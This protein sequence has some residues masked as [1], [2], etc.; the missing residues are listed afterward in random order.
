[1]PCYDKLVRDNIPDIIKSSGKQCTYHIAKDDKEFKKA[2][3][4]KLCE[5]V[6]EYL[7]NPNIEELSDIL[8]IVNNLISYYG[9]NAVKDVYD[10]KL[11]NNGDF[12][13][14]IILEK[15]EG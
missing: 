15:V 14:K 2:V 6:L 1:M 3:D 12:K 7:N 9:E 11:A 10:S 4:N 8:L 5:E 13:N